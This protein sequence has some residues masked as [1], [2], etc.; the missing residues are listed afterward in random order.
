VEKKIAETYL[1]LEFKMDRIEGTTKKGRIKVNNAYQ[2][3]L[4]QEGGATK[5]LEKVNLP[6]RYPLL[7]ETRVE[8][9]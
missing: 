5:Y 1:P 4:I 7:N 8:Y 6:Y 2:K 9:R 3:R